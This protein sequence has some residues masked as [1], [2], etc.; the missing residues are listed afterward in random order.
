VLTLFYNAVFSRG[1]TRCITISKL[2]NSVTPKLI[3]WFSTNNNNWYERRKWWNKWVLR[4][5]M[6]NS[7]CKKIVYKVK[8]KRQSK[9]PYSIHIL[10]I[11]FSFRYINFFLRIKN[12]KSDLHRL[13][14]TRSCTS[15][16]MPLVFIA[17]TVS[18][19]SHKTFCHYYAS[20]NYSLGNM[21]RWTFHILCVHTSISEF[22]SKWAHVHVC[23]CACKICQCQIM[24]A[25]WK[26]N[27]KI[28]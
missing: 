24:N 14:Y 23:E 15:L 11:K 26:F 3:K 25:F 27:R 20:Y 17:T 19:T 10:L 13:I 6:C 8:T 7:V 28:L 12:I 22:A 1:K 4:N 21:C 18:S 9:R 16:G 2:L 5:I